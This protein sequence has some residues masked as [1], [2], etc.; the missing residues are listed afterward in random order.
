M[1]QLQPGDLHDGR[2]PSSDKERPLGNALAF[3]R[4]R[5]YYEPVVDNFC[6]GQLNSMPPDLRASSQAEIYP[7]L[8]AFGDS[9]RVTFWIASGA[10]ERK[11]FMQLPNGKIATAQTSA[12]VN[13]IFHDSGKANI[14]WDETAFLNI[15]VFLRRAKTI[16]SG[17]LTSKSLCRDFLDIWNCLEDLAKTLDLHTQLKALKKPALLSVY[18]KLYQRLELPL[19]NPQEAESTLRWNKAEAEAFAPAMTQLWQAILS[20]SPEILGRASDAQLP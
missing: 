14:H 13:V 15:D 18:Q 6:H 3:S 12:D 8:I 5:G 16:R 10:G 4:L 19:P 17:Q 20:A 1:I 2:V 7:V 11:H 9:V